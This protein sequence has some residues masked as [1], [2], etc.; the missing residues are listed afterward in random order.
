MHSNQF[1]MQC[2]SAEDA[3]LVCQIQLCSNQTVIII[4]HNSLEMIDLF[5][6]LRDP[7]LQAIKQGLDYGCIGKKADKYEVQHRHECL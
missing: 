1:T 5:T 3:H 7:I 2:G 6:N 4:R